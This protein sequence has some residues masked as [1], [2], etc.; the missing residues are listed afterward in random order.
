M[1]ESDK[2]GPI[3]KKIMQATDFSLINEATEIKKIL[4]EQ[5]H[6]N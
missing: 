6:D 2:H 4:K 3:P 1:S 5:N